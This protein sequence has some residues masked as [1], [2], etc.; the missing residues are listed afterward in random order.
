MRCDSK[1]DIETWNMKLTHTFV[2]CEGFI[3]SKGTLKMFYRCSLVGRHE[4]GE[5]Q[6][7]RTR[8][9]GQPNKNLTLSVWK[10]MYRCIEAS[11][12]PHTHIKN[13]ARM[14]ISGT[15]N[16]PRDHSTFVPLSRASFNN[17]CQIVQGGSLFHRSKEKATHGGRN[18]EANRQSGLD[19]RAIY[20]FLFLPRA[21][22]CVVSWRPLL[23]ISSRLPQSTLQTW[24]V[25]C[26]EW[27]FVRASHHSPEKQLPMFR[28]RFLGRMPS[29]HRTYPEGLFKD[30]R[31]FWTD[32]NNS[33]PAPFFSNS[34]LKNTPPQK[35]QVSSGFRW[36]Q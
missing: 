23:R 1:F 7:Q 27:E 36:F 16:L 33:L 10:N 34:K 2:V 5:G 32:S 31:L 19:L 3:W 35:Q 29:E 28:L 25:D 21:T 6:R 26:W 8:L 9:S 24:R 20:S 13:E 11:T 12:F 17:A 18:C 14:S 22:H 15:R 4:K 30:D